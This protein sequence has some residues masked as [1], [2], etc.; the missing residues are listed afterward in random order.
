MALLD[1]TCPL[2]E[3]PHAKKLSLIH[4]EG[5]AN[6]YTSMHSVGTF[7]TIGR[8]KITTT[9]TVA[10]IQQTD[11][12]RRAAP[13]FVPPLVSDATKSIGS[14]VFGG[15]LII[16]LVCFMAGV[17]GAAAETILFMVIAMIVA[18]FFIARSLNVPPT[19][20][21]IELYQAENKD[22][23]EAYRKWENTFSCNSCG[24][25]FIPEES[26]G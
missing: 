4:S 2:C 19:Q 26:K 24:H 3:A 15:L 18:L 13:P 5:L 7:N 8:Q 16:V 11:A 9:G 12:S 21:E 20:K 23:L 10:G 14:L 6:V 17:S 22:Q 1:T 25:R